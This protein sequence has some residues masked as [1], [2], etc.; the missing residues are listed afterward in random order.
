MQV[1]LLDDLS[2]IGKYNNKLRWAQKPYHQ[3]REREWRRHG[4]S[5]TYKKFL[6]LLNKQGYLCNIC[7]SVIDETAHVDHNHNTGKVRGIL[8]R[9][10]NLLL[11]RAQ[12]NV[13]ILKNA[14]TYLET[15]DD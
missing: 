9:R 3:K 12:D 2:S 14:I 7:G 6:Q 1:S 10:C 8:C 4:I 11:A 13:Q 5:L 15:E